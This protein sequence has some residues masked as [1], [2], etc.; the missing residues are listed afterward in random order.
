MLFLIALALVLFIG[1][2]DKA[3]D[4]GQLPCAGWQQLTTTFDGDVV[5]IAASSTH[6]WVIGGLGTVCEVGCRGTEA[7]LALLTATGGTT[8][9]PT[10][11]ATKHTLRV[12]G[13]HAGTTQCD[14]V[15]AQGTLTAT[16]TVGAR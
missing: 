12:T 14:V 13:V 10:A 4:T 9:Q 8:T 15:A 11:I 16:I 5:T 6:D 7:E 2:T 3:T 1:C